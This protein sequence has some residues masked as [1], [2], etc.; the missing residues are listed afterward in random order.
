MKLSQIRIIFLVSKGGRMKDILNRINQMIRDSLVGRYGTDEL[1]KF[2]LVITLILFVLSLFIQNRILYILAFASLLYTYYRI[3]SRN[4]AARRLENEKFM[5]VVNTVRKQSRISKKRFEGRRD[6]RFFKCPSCGQ[7]VR[8]PKGK[9]RIRI[10]CP[11]CRTQFD[12][13]V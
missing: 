4:F 9:G 10:T 12:R 13:T 6:Y 1:S 3:L 11:K 7:E 5:G 8:V 2:L